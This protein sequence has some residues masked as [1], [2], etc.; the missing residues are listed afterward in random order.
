M[1]L[2]KDRMSGNE[3][4]EA[5]FNYNK[6]DRVPINMIT[7][8]FPCKN[9]G[10][11]IT[12]G[13]DNPEIF[14]QAFI[15]TAEQYGWDMIPQNC[16]HI[17][18][19][20]RDFGGDVRLPSG[21]YEGALV[22][23]SYPVDSEA[24][25][26]ELELPDIK[27]IGQIQKSLTLSKLQAEN[28]LPVTFVSRSPFTMASNICGLEKFSKWIIK[29]PE[30]CKRMMDLAFQHICN[31][32][33]LWVDTFGSKNIF[34]LLT[35][36]SESNQV[37]SPKHFEKFA[38]PYHIAY[39]EKIKDLGIRRFMFHICGDQNRNLP[40]LSSGKPWPHPSILSFGHEVDLE[41]ASR[42][43]PEDIIFGNVD[44]AVIQM[45]TPQEV[46]EITR[47]TI[48]KGKKASGG[49][50]LSSGCELPPLAPPVNVFAMTK[51]V[52]DFGW[53]S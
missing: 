12:A 14:F 35:S 23:R 41:T 30:L 3:R 44:P 52:N 7:V 51:A 19:G 48:E 4:M 27:K 31:A 5:L 53:Y 36:P 45:R 21:E 1:L 42:M 29:K 13:Y 37:I 46:Y 40:A 6:P 39:H 47:K 25:I 49:F 32:L 9:A 24:E 11:P 33:D 28:N 34:S 16:P 38:L 8:G 17:V 18:L 15:W 10:Q 43:F 2:K 22:V 20:A 50:V 26:E